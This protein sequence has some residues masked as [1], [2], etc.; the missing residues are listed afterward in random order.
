MWAKQSHLLNP[1]TSLMSHKV[2]F[3]WTNLETKAF[4]GIKRAVPQE[5]L[6]AYP[7]FNEHF[8]IHTDSRDYQLGAVIIHNGKPI[9][10]FIRKL[11]GP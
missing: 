9:A 10:F 5:T 3:K 2:R 7:D 11:T 8:D 4:D 6:L 1:L